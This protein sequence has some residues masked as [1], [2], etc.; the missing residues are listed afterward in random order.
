MS[1]LKGS[2]YGRKVNRGRQLSLHFGIYITIAALIYTFALMIYMH[3]KG[4]KTYGSGG[5]RYSVA[6]WLGI[7]LALAGVALFFLSLL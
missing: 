4:K 7:G 3:V 2:T 5:A 6:L 1:S